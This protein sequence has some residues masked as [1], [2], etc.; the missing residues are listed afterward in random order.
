[1]TDNEVSQLTHSGC[2]IYPLQWMEVDENAHL[3]RGNDYSAVPPRYKSRLVGCGNFGT[4]EDVRANSPAADVDSHNSVCSWC[5]HSMYPFVLVISPTVT[6]K[7]ERKTDL[8]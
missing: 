5:S 8:C 6:F 1:M 4:T 3:C 2:E 7:D